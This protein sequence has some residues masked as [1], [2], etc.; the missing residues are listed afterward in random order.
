MSE[1]WFSSMV[2]LPA[3]W[4][5]PTQQSAPMASWLVR[6]LWTTGTFPYFEGGVME[7]LTIRAV[8]IQVLGGLAFVFTVLAIIILGSMAQ[9]S[10]GPLP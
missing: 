3:P 10:L 6:S 9:V 5:T 1:M 8:I 4:F 2:Q 7:D